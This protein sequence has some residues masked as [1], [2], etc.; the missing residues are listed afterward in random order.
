MALLLAD[1][2][3]DHRIVRALR[4]M[5]HDVVTLPLLGLCDAGTPDA[6]VLE[7]ASTLGRAVLTHDRQDF[8]R[9]HRRGSNLL[10][11][12]V[13]SPDPDSQAVASR[14]HAEIDGQQ[15]L[16]AQLLRVNLPKQ[17]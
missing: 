11:V 1:E 4:S 12:I 8:V 3:F 13:V 14:I 17:P 7:S 6:E 16:S 2:N 9:L 5:G 15:N 10:G